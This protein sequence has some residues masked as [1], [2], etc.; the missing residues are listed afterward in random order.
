MGEPFSHALRTHTSTSLQ[1]GL[2]QDIDLSLI[3]IP[4]LSFTTKVPCYVLG[5][6]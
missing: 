6:I 4:D 1:S 2:S 3:K 5:A